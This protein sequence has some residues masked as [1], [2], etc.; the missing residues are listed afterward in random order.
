MKGF[1]LI[2]LLVVVLIIGILSAIALPQYE[3][4]VE[5]SRAS[6]AMINAKAIIDA[7]QRHEQEFPG[8][9]CVRQGQIADV[10]LKGG[11]WNATDGSG[12]C[13]IT[14]KFVYDL[15]S[16]EG[17]LYVGRSDSPSCSDGSSDLYAIEF[18]LGI[19]DDRIA[20]TYNCGAD[21]D[22]EQVCKLFTDL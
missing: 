14:K 21:S 17:N 18:G 19:D 2:E 12:T 1:T 4:V 13:F 15:G 8:E 16:T 10:Q 6:E 20:G 11:S 9:T 3:L 22:Y 7:C 5:K